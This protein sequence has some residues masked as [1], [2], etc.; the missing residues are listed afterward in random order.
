MK[1]FQV[2]NEQRGRFGGEPAV[3]DLTMRLLGT[4]GH[5]PRLIMKSSRALEDS[6]LARGAAFWGGVF[7]VRA[8]REMR[9]TI[10]DERPD[11]VH[12]HS[13]Y[14]MFSP[15]ILVACR[16]AGIPVVM[17][18]HSNNLTCPTWFHLHKGRI[19]ED[20]VGGREY[21]CV[22]KNCRNNILESSAYALRSAFA[23]RFRLF[24]DNVDVSIAFTP[25]GKSRLILA[26]FRE[27]QIA[28]IP[29]PSSIPPGSIEPLAGEYIAY[30][31][32]IS[33][34]KGVHVLLAAAARMP[35]VPFK[36]AGDGP[37]Y[38]ELKAKAAPNVE[39]LGRLDFDSLVAFYR[40]ALVLAVP[41][42]WYEPCP[43]VVMDAMSLGLP[44]VASRIG[45]L[46]HLVDDGVTGLLFEPDNPEDLAVRL[47][48]LW[49]DRGRSSRFGNAGREKA[50][51]EFAQ[52]TYY[53][54]LMAAYE[55]AKAHSIAGGGAIRP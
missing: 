27:E 37:V 29:N 36:I 7:N 10:E 1:V 47:R 55:T 34:E 9:R 15:S 44:V 2:Y 21:H 11:L 53:R 26:G 20:C 32:R 39:F 41:S 19:C 6:I 48:E 13:V 46:P 35:D 12:V 33:P 31:G 8:Y 45:G 25:F 49:E 17:T 14:P 24:H 52:S 30:S 22:L 40:R 3:V 5:F 18:V 23:R 4:N 50:S 28:V 51:R 16:R 43:M 42:Q 38:S 54:R